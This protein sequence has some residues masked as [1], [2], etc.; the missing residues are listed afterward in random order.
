MVVY[1][2][3]VIICF[4]RIDFQPGVYALEVLTSPEQLTVL[5]QPGCGVLNFLTVRFEALYRRS[6]ANPVP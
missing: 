5:F 6:S 3:A 4:Y 1:Q 2:C